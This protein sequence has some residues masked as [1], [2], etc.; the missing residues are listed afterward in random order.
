M[1]SRFAGALVDMDGTLYRGDTPIEGAREAIDTLREAGVAVQF[2]TNNPTKSPENYV[3]K[4]A[5]MGID[6]SPADI[7]TA[8]V[9]TAD[10]LRREHR[11]ENL[12]VVGEPDLKQ[13]LSEAGLSLTDDPAATDVVVLSLDTGLD[14][15]L[16]TRV[17]RA[18]TPGTP[19]V[20]T[21]PDRTKPGT[22]GILPSA[23]VVI[24]AVEGMTGRGPDVVAGKPSEVAAR[25]ALDRLGVPSER[26]LLVGDRLDT[27]IEM[28]SKTGM[29]TVL[30]RTGVTDDAALSGSEVDP[31]YVLDSIADIER[32]LD[33][34][35]G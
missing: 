26:C 10:Y 12:F 6:A 8:G 32:V 7:V 5:G 24:G 4:L 17:L 18:V 14:H 1:Q 2:L 25:F 31:D 21:N 30:V 22:D 3:K 27:D 15:D 28:G 20:A 34:A 23:G 35:S 13:V 19:I 16:F 9:V 11:E 29:T 33:D